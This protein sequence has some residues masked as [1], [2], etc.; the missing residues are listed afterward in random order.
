MKAGDIL[1]SQWG[2]EQTSVCFY[3]VVKV[4]K[5]TVQLVKINKKMTPTVCRQFYAMPLPGT[6]YGE[7]F[8]SRIIIC[9]SKQCC[10]ITDYEYAYLWD[11]SPQHGSFCT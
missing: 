4:M 10:R 2:Y 6:R 8:C 7:P 1:V 5:N 9:K 11:G 3:E